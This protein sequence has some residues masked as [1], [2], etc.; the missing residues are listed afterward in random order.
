[1]KKYQAESKKS[2]RFLPKTGHFD[3]KNG[4]FYK[5]FCRILDTAKRVSKM[6]LLPTDPSVSLKFVKKVTKKVLTLPCLRGI[7]YKSTRYGNKTKAK[8]ARQTKGLAKRNYFRFKEREES[9]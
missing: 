3:E 2:R 8:I 5:F 1:M 7:I 4:Y 9:K 6:L